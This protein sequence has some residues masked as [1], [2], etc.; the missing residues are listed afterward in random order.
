MRGPFDLART[1]ETVS[2][3]PDGKSIALGYGGNAGEGF[4]RVVNID[5]RREV[6]RLGRF[7]SPVDRIL[8][9]ADGSA[10]V[11][12][13]LPDR[14][15]VWSARQGVRLHAL[16]GTDFG[17]SP[18][19]RALAVCAKGRKEHNEILIVDPAGGRLI[20]TIEHGSQTARTPRFSPDGRRVV[21]VLCEPKKYGHPCEYRAVSWDAR[22]GKRRRRRK[23]WKA[24]YE[25][26]WRISPD[27]NTIASGSETGTVRLWN[28]TNDEDPIPLH[29]LFG[30]V[31]CLA[32]SPS[33]KALA[34]GSE[35][36]T[37]YVWSLARLPALEPRR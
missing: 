33:G 36:G 3:S 10:F 25:T 28:A 6:I 31:R 16:R 24:F 11:T 4:V 21:A 34:A 8:F 9:S 5:E 29:G 7:T 20:T 18:D 2:A 19:G 23:L 14:I 26:P 35:D 30:G 37:I 32:F 1:I 15:Y 27:A 17:L 13:S 12:R 22:T